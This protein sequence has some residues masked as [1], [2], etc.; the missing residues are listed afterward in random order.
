MS[1]V[2]CFYYQFLRFGLSPLVDKGRRKSQRRLQLNCKASSFRMTAKCVVNILDNATGILNQ[3]DDC[4]NVV[5]E[6][7]SDESI[8]VF[9]LT[10]HWSMVL[11]AVLFGCVVLNTAG[12]AFIIYFANEEAVDRP[13]NTMVLIDQVNILSFQMSPIKL[14]SIK[15]LEILGLKAQSIK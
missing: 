3:T 10:T 9:G 6:D 5:L 12:K 8:E 13:M 15:V 7:M 2:V 4:P 14:K 1:K 11:V